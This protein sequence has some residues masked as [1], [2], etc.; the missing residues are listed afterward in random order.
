MS[1]APAKVQSLYSS[2]MSIQNHTYSIVSTARTIGA[3]S[4]DATSECDDTHNKIASSKLQVI[5]QHGS[6]VAEDVGPDSEV[7][8]DSSPRVHPEP[9]CVV[10]SQISGTTKS[11]DD[12]P[13]RP[14]D[15]ILPE[16]TISAFTETDQEESS[17]AVP[18]Q[19]ALVTVSLTLDVASKKGLS[20]RL[21][22]AQHWDFKVR[23]TSLS[24]NPFLLATSRVRETVTSLTPCAVL[25]IQG[26]LD[27]F[28]TTLRTS[29][30]LDTPS[31]SP[32]LEDCIANSY[33]FGMAYSRLRRIWYT[34]DWSTIRAEVCRWEEEDQEMR[35]KAVVGNQIVNPNLAPRRV[36]DLWSNRVVPLW[37]TGIPITTVTAERWNLMLRPISHAWMDEEDRADVSTP[38][39][40]YE[41]PVLIPKDANLNLIRIEMLNLGAE[42]AWL[43]VLCLRQKG[44]PREDVRVEE[45]KLDVPTIGRVYR[46]SSVA[47]YLSGLGLP[48]TLKE[49]DLDSDRSWFRHA[50]TLQE[51]GWPRLRVI[52]GD[53]PQGPM[54]ARHKDG[55]Y[56]T[57]LLTRFHELLRFIDHGTLRHEVFV[58]L[59]GMQKRVSTNPVD[60]VAGLAFCL[61]SDVIPAYY[62]SQSLEKA[63]TALL[64]SMKAGSR[65]VL[66][67]WCPEPGNAGTKWR[68]SWDQIMVNPLPDGIY[69][70]DDVDRDEKTNE[71]SCNMACIEK[72]LVRGLAV[73]G[74]DRHGELIVKEKGGMD[75]HRF[76]IT[77]THKYP[78]LEDT[79]TLILAYYLHG[80]FPS[81]YY[82]YYVIG[83]S[84][85][86]KRFEKVSVLQILDEGEVG[87]LRDLHNDIATWRRYILV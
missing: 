9:A 31:L 74:G 27:L 55:K 45:W 11:D 46:M 33:D 23:F 10:G 84:L 19:R 61:F 48:L 52:A 87:R 2:V 5:L 77:A 43:D 20:E 81:R 35:R 24:D 3:S 56:E 69:T 34:R 1:L 62:E 82:C 67:L 75:S 12:E 21:P 60:K 63:W 70:L 54:H 25:G 28:N 47:C 79:Y 36:W 76:K 4:P 29:H 83:R 39:N 16:V 8:P 32:L 22:P 71:Y 85:P 26:L 15:I 30:S 44:G 50:W 53:T 40:G 57:E 80:I 17:I 58:A 73:G 86:E 14:K 64:N 49:G 6:F 13:W 65:G 7:I 78:I 72:G 18:L 41:W 38:I 51:L 37:S 68:P 42:Y 66:F 59:E